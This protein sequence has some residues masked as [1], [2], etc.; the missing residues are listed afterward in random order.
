MHGSSTRTLISP[1][2]SSFGLWNPKICPFGA[3]FL[4]LSFSLP[5][6]I[7]LSFNETA[8]TEREKERERKRNNGKW[9]RREEKITISFSFRFCYCFRPLCLAAPATDNREK[10]P[11]CLSLNLFSLINAFVSSQS[12]HPQSFKSYPYCGSNY[13]HSRL[14]IIMRHLRDHLPVQ[15]KQDLL[16]HPYMRLPQNDPCRRRVPFSF[17][18]GICIYNLIYTCVWIFKFKVCDIYT[19]VFFSFTTFT[20]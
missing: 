18:H 13:N 2:S 7:S 9:E 15:T 6:S 3:L 10:S 1:S 19:C 4:F 8:L 12:R 14:F 17:L 11:K 5:L 16:L 20:W